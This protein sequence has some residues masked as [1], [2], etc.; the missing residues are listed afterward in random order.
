MFKVY[1]YQIDRQTKDKQHI[2]MLHLVFASLVPQNQTDKIK[3]K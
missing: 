3:T 2:L 1:M